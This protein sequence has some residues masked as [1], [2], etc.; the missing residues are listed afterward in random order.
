MPAEKTLKAQ[1]I[2]HKIVPEPKHISPDCG[3]CIRVDDEHLKRAGKALDG[4]V[5]VLDIRMIPS[6]TKGELFLR[7]PESRIIIPMG[8]SRWYDMTITKNRDW[9]HGV[10]GDRPWDGKG[11]ADMA[12]MHFT[13]VYSIERR[14][15]EESQ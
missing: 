7:D 14:R 5:K 1:G 12:A 6:G 2:P 4:T 11:N 9:S 10:A 8:P 13:R 3:V 15:Y